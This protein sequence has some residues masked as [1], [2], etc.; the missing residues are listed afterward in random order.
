MLAAGTESLKI[1]LVLFS[2]KYEVLCI[3][4]TNLCRN[5]LD[6][7][8][9]PRFLCEEENGA[10]LDFTLMESGSVTDLL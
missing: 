4:E 8:V 6:I 1:I 7:T 9:L 2:A 5:L 10:S 3:L